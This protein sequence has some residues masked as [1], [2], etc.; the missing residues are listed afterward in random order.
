M[1]RADRD[2][3]KWIMSFGFKPSMLCEQVVFFERKDTGEKLTPETVE[4]FYQQIKKE[5][6]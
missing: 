1:K 5:Q 2:V 3:F 4:L 6:K